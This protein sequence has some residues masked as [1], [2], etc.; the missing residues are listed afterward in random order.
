[1]KAVA[2]IITFLVPLFWVS[3]VFAEGAEREQLQTLGIMVLGL[4]GL[5]GIR[6]RTSV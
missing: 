5:F 2:L 1:M 4:V 6:R 3:A